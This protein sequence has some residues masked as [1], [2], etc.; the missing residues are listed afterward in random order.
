MKK[1]TKEEAANRPVVKRGRR[2][3]VH[4]HMLHLKPGE[5]LIVDK[6]ADW[7]GKNPPYRLVSRFAKK[8]GW[9]MTWGESLDEKSFEITRVE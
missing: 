1:L 7:I 3:R 9:K 5:I 2:T 6:G 4:M 8:R